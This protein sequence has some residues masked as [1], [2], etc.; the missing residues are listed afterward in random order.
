MAFVDQ[1]GSACFQTS[2]MHRYSE[3]TLLLLLAAVQ[4]AHPR[5]HG[6]HA[7]GA[8][9]DAGTGDFTGWLQSPGGGLH[10]QR[11]CGRFPDGAVH[12]SVRSA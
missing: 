1:L 9:I 8:A 3:R 2:S 12:G 10:H 11:G 6:H 7:V 5:F 4:F